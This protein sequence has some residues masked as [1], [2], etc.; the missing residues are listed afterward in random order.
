MWGKLLLAAELHKIWDRDAMSG[1][2]TYGLLV[3]PVLV[4]TFSQRVLDHFLL[5]ERCAAAFV[6]YRPL[7]L[8]MRAWLSVVLCLSVS[9]QLCW[10][11][12]NLI[13]KESC[14]HYFSGKLLACHWQTS[15]HLRLWITNDDGKSSPLSLTRRM[16]RSHQL[17]SSQL[18]L[19]LNKQD[20]RF[21][22]EQLNQIC[23]LVCFLHQQC[24]SLLVLRD[25][26][27]ELSDHQHS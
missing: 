7:K 4:S 18:D 24:W 13:Q 21:H 5:L 22:R 27:Q 9:R 14:P 16:A 1:L 8:Q 10:A 23:P 3:Y 20:F 12:R 17:Y 26:E 19:Y 15:L 6:V 25:E 2:T 11:L